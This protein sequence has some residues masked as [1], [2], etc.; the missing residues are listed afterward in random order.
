MLSFGMSSPFSFILLAVVAFGMKIEKLLADHIRTAVLLLPPLH[1]TKLSYYQHY[2]Q[3]RLASGS[4]TPP[5]PPIATSGSSTP[6]T[7]TPSSSSSSS[8]TVSKRSG[9]LTEEMVLE[10]LVQLDQHQPLV[11]S[12]FT[13]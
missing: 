9:V 3:L 13:A 4:L 11:T 2:L 8:S 6:P 7:V 12:L 5:P 1:N 10:E